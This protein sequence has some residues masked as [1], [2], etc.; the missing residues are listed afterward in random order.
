MD[1]IQK[2]QEKYE[3]RLEKIANKLLTI[4]PTELEK[5]FENSSAQSENL[6]LENFFLF[7]ERIKKQLR[8]GDLS[9]LQVLLWVRE[10]IKNNRKLTQSH[11]EICEK[12][13]LKHWKWVD[14]SGRVMSTIDN[15]DMRDTKHDHLIV[16]WDITRSLF[17]K[18][19]R[20]EITGS[21]VQNVIEGDSLNNNIQGYNW[22]NNIGGDNWKNKI[23][24]NNWKNK[25]GGNNSGNNIEEDNL[26]NDIE[27][28]NSENQIRGN[29]KDNSSCQMITNGFLFSWNIS[30]FR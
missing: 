11:I 2:L 22:G 4:S 3:L 17:S 20:V 6:K 8:T 24:G 27:G 14:V 23:G 7:L 21:V 9:D 15:Y 19:E 12:Y 16:K 13:W 18:L 10:S 26:L 25:I 1:N 5:Y 28:D 29:N 30:P